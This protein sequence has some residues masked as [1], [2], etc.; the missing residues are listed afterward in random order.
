[1][2]LYGID[3]ERGIKPRGRVAHDDL[4]R[5]HV[6]LLCA[7]EN[8]AKNQHLC[9]PQYR[10][11][12]RGWYGGIQRALIIDDFV[13]SMSQLGLQVNALRDPEDALRAVPWQV[14]ASRRAI[15]LAR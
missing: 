15:S 1:M 3:P 7:D 11:Q 8:A 12:W 13:Y 4:A 5:E 9:Q 2:V 10:E 14:L 6:A